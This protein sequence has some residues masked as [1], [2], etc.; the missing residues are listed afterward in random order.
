MTEGAPSALCS[1]SSISVILLTTSEAAMN[2]KLGLLKDF[3]WQR[4][5][6]MQH[7]LPALFGAQ[8]MCIQLQSCIGLLAEDA[9]IPAWC[10]CG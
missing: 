6:A 7:L 5:L 8:A 9:S 3:D 10:R 1:T 4:Q 2:I